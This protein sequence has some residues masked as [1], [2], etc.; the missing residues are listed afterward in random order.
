MQ[1][2][3][4]GHD[5]TDTTQQGSFNLMLHVFDLNGQIQITAPANAETLKTPGF[6][7]PS[8]TK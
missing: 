1:M 8:P 3:V 7:V 5:K 2:T 6:G 4:K